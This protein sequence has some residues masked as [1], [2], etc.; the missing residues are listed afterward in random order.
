MGGTVLLY[1]CRSSS[2]CFESA[3]LRPNVFEHPTG[4]GRDTRRPRSNI[5]YPHSKIPCYTMSQNIC[6]A[7]SA[8]S[9]T[10]EASS[11]FNH[12]KVTSLSG[13]E[14][15]FLDSDTHS[16][17]HGITSIQ[18]PSASV[19]SLRIEAS[20]FG[21][22]RSV[23]S[24]ESVY[25]RL[26]PKMIPVNCPRNI[27]WLGM[28]CRGPRTARGVNHDCLTETTGSRKNPDDSGTWTTHW[29]GRRRLAAA[30]NLRQ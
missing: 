27:P 20:R 24:G 5:G 18:H 9:A 11:P 7:S 14:P 13:H 4:V 26:F 6:S 21:R 8:R 3:L 30:V 10:A 23:C 17:A 16:V 1:A 15:S 22:V 12:L 2:Q 28:S 29:M 25:G 19:P